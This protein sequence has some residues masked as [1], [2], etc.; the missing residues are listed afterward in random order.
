MPGHGWGWRRGRP[1]KP[2]II[3]F[4]PRFPAF[5]PAEYA[6]GLENP[7]VIMPDE[8]EAMRLVDYEG[9]LQEEAAAMMGISRGTVWRLLESGRRKLL[10]MIIEGRPL[11]V[12]GL[13]EREYVGGG[14]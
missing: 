2:R 12:A 8:L 9:H 11:V 6:E 1:P 3:R 14:T 10:S 4:M 7:I 5:L 13:E